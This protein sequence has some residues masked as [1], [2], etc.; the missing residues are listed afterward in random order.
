VLPCDV[1]AQTLHNQTLDAITKHAKVAVGNSQINVGGGPQSI[2][3]YKHADSPALLYV[4]N[5]FSNSVSVVT[6]SDNTILKEIP[7]GD[8]PKSLAIDYNP[9]TGDRIYVVNSGKDSNSVSVITPSNN[10]ILKEIPVMTDPEDLAVDPDI[11][12]IYV[13]NSGDNSVSVIN[14]MTLKVIKNITVGDKPE[15]LAV[16]PDTHTIYVANS[17]SNSVSVMNETSLNVTRTITVG[18]SPVHLAVDTNRRAIYVANFDSGGISVIDG[19]SNYVVTGAAFD[20]NPPNSGLIKCNKNQTTPINQYLYLR[21]GTTCTAD[22]NKGFEFSGWVENLSHNSTSTLSTTNS[23]DSASSSILDFFGIKPNDTATTFNPTK[24][25]SFT[26]NFKAVPPPIPPEYLL[27]IFGLTV[28]IIIP[29]IFRW[30]NG[31]RQRR[32]LDKCIKKIYSEKSKTLGQQDA[33]KEV[34]YSSK[35]DAE[36]E[37]RYLY[38]K[39]KISESHLEKL[40]EMIAAKFKV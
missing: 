39:G 6:T 12:T 29:S 25:G 19:V 40:N 35:D 33:E 8:S 18:A 4:A 31:W 13:A 24:F 15:D 23:T 17:G 7:V 20:I 28:S 10:T 5:Y 3:V 16:D 32:N 2:V 14:G 22:P 9:H 27:A 38:I 26:A 37:V 36:K 34:R 11:H 1:Y 30:I 21:S